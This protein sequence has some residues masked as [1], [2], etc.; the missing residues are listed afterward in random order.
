MATAEVAAVCDLP[1][2]RAPAELWKLALEW[3][4]RPRSVPGGELWAPPDWRSTGPE[5]TSTALGGEVTSRRGRVGL[6]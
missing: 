4:V 3:R 2:L 5:R 1:G 6:A